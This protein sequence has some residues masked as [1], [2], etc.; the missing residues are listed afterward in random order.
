MTSFAGLRAVRQLGACSD[1]EIASLL[2][3]TDEVSLRAGEVVAEKGRLCS[4]FVMVLDGALRT[5]RSL[6]GPGDSIGWAAMWERGSNPSRVVVESDA[7][8]LVMS[9]AQF[10]AVKGLSKIEMCGSRPLSLSPS[11]AN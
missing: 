3:F 2:R 1:R 4:E 5:E 10:R 6:L 7:R 11:L 8:L 9:H